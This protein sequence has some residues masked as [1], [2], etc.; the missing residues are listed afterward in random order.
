MSKVIYDLGDLGPFQD[1][2]EWNASAL[3]GWHF[4]VLAYPTEGYDIG[5]YWDLTSGSSPY[6]TQPAGSFNWSD[7]L[8]FCR[9]GP[10][11]NLILNDRG[12][13]TLPLRSQIY[14]ILQ[15]WESVTHGLV[16]QAVFDI[17]VTETFANNV[18]TSIQDILMMQGFSGVP[19]VSPEMQWHIKAGTITITHAF[20]GDFYF[21]PPAESQ[22]IVFPF[23][24]NPSSLGVPWARRYENAFLG[25]PFGTWPELQYPVINGQTIYAA[26]FPALMA[27]AT[28]Y[29]AFIDIE[30]VRN[31]RDLGFV[32]KPLGVLPIERPYPLE[33]T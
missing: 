12:P 25:Y 9:N 19:G 28:D 22:A 17:T 21:A 33:Q 11:A 15:E 20:H 27:V 24:F 18:H 13:I 2:A 30:F 4:D 1:V 26:N 6:W 3:G 10:A 31:W 16:P 14:Y 29:G 8:S 23:M 7:R 5:F 32:N